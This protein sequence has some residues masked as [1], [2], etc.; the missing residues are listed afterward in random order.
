MRVVPVEGVIEV[1]GLTGVLELLV[2]GVPRW[3]RV[4]RV[5]RI[6]RVSTI[7]IMSRFRWVD[8]VSMNKVH[9][10]HMLSTHEAH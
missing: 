4:V 9:R 7:I 3:K 6:T 2:V 8:K 10:T 5:M 1:L